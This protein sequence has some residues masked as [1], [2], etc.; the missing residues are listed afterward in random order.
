MITERLTAPGYCS[1]TETGILASA[2]RMTRYEG[3]NP[4][5]FPTPLTIK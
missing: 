3:S 2:I 1:R 5:Y 4:S